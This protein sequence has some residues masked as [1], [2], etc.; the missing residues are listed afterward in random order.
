VP[1]GAD[2][3]ENLCSAF[4][5]LRLPKKTCSVLGEEA[6]VVADAGGWPG[7]AQGG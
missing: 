5:T 1:P 4:R 2:C 3:Q 6:V 7:G